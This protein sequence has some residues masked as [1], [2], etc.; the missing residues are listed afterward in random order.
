MPHIFAVFKTILL[1]VVSE[2]KNDVEAGNQ[3]HRRNRAAAG[4]RM[5]EAD[6]HQNGPMCLAVQAPTRRPE[7]LPLGKKIFQSFHHAKLQN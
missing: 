6:A 5:C 2:L 7:E 1:C 3:R 4:G